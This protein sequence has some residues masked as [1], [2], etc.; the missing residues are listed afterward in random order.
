MSGSYVRDYGGACFEVAFIH[1]K[2]CLYVTIRCVPGVSAWYLAS[3]NGAL[4]HA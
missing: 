4:T 3:K 2:H 1:N